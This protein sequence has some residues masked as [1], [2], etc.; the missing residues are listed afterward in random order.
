MLKHYA[1]KNKN[2]KTE[3]QTSLAL[4]LKN[5]NQNFL[6]DFKIAQIKAQRNFL[7]STLNLSYRLDN[8]QINLDSKYQNKTTLTPTLERNAL[9]NALALKLTFN[10]NQRTSFSFLNQKSKF[11]HLNGLEAGSAKHLQVNVNYIL[12]LGYPDIS[13]NSYLSHHKFSKNIAADF[14]EFGIASSIGTTRKNTLNSSWKPFGTVAFAINDQHAIG[15]S[16]TLG[17]SKILKGDDSLD[18]LFDYYNGIGVISEPIYGL[19]VKYRF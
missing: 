13:F 4:S 16:L 1:Y 7:N 17:V 18:L 10:L 12:R 8:F 2:R 14:S 11:T 6:W 3:E 5:S 19:N 9:E 15:S